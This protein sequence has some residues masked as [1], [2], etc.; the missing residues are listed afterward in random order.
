M[1]QTGVKIGDYLKKKKKH[2]VGRRE[3]GKA[4]EKGRDVEDGCAAVA[5]SSV[6]C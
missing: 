6:K 4:G 2:R 3:E 5:A 1:T